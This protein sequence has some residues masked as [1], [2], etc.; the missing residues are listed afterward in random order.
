MTGT[1]TYI[2]PFQSTLSVRRATCRKIENRYYDRISIHALRKE[3]DLRY[4]LYITTR[5]ISIHALRKES[6]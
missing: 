3:S 1:A 2:N 4:H 5:I 6:D